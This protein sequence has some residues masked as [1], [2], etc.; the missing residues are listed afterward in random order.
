MKKA[1]YLVYVISAVIFIIAHYH[2]NNLFTTLSKPL[3]LIVLL[4]LISKKSKYNKYITAG[5][6]FSLIG[7]VFLMNN[8]GLFLLGLIAFLIAHLFYIIAFINNSKKMVLLSYLPFAAYGFAFFLFIKYSLGDALIPVACYIFIITLM[9]WR[10]FVQRKSGTLAKWA[11]VGAL[12][13]TL[14][15]SVLAF[16][17]FYKP[18][19][20]DSLAIMITYWAAQFLIYLSTIKADKKN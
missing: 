11:F 10:A 2:Q 16:A 17:R 5:L 8:V 4:I 7:D 9:L 3:P 20:W 15:D 19:F 1:L 13:F 18:F 12:F 6:I 14:S